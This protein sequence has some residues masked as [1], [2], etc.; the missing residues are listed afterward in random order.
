MH[1]N[2]GLQW[3]RILGFNGSELWASMDSNYGLRILGFN[4]FE[5][6]NT[7][8]VGVCLTHKVLVSVA[9]A[10]SAKNVLVSIAN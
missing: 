9:M 6:W 4:E 8:T 10:S 3:I 2:F 7:G 5:F 1:S